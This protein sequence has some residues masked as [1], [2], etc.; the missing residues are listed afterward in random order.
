MLYD[1][2]KNES[3]PLSFDN[4]DLDSIYSNIC[5]YITVVVKGTV[6]ELKF[7]DI[8]EMFTILCPKIINFTPE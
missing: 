5:F 3:V 8:I 6:F 1:R 4:I 2:P 7:K